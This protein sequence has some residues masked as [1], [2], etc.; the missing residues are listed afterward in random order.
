MPQLARYEYLRRRSWQEVVAPHDLRHAHQQ[1][2]HR[3]GQSVASAVWV[4]RKGEI[5]QRARD[6]LLVWTCEGVVKAHGRSVRHA[7]TPTRNSR[8]TGRRRIVP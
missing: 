5:A 6:V 8:R 2:V 1:V 3:D 4:A 7:E